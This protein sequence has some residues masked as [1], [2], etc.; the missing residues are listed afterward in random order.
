MMRPRIN[1]VWIKRDIRSQDHLPLYSAEQSELPYLVIY[2]FEPSIITYKDTS[3]RH[4]QFQYHAIQHLNEKWKSCNK[5][6]RV[7][8]AE[9]IEVFKLI[10]QHFTIQHLFSYRE[11][12][13]AIT[14]ERDKHVASFCKANGIEW[15]QSQRD[16]ILRGNRNREGWDKQWFVT[17]HSKVIE[18]HHTIREQIQI[19]EVYN[20][21]ESFLL[22]VNNFPQE[23][24]PPG[25][26]YAFKYLKSFVDE[27]GKNY[28]RHISKPLESRTGCMRISP[29]ISWGNISVR[30]AYQFVYQSLATSGFKKP[31]QNA[32]TRL[33]W[34]CH[35]IQKFENE[36]AY[37]TQC[38][39]SGYELLEHGSN[40][41]FIEAWKHGQTGY[42]LVDACMRCLIKTGWINFRMRAMLVSFLCFHLDQ[43]WRAGVYH[44]AQLFLD[45]EPGIHYPQFQMQAGTTGIN[46]VRIYNPIKQSRD[47]DPEGVF[48]RLWV[49]ELR[50]VP[51]DFIHEPH[52][53]SQLEQEMYGVSIGRD[54]PAPIVDLESSGKTA[55]DKIWG[56]RK[57]EAVK[58]DG[59]RILDRHVRKART[60]KEI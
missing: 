56:H 50:F 37:E 10:N 2:I 1:V 39:N 22:Q 20:L 25:E 24:Q 42:P 35:F 43:D 13:T 49:P 31:L 3:L 30:Q 29:Y 6:V 9:A 8:Y 47:H 11:S 51:G 27:R 54:Y 58:L 40:E 36:C 34:H 26:D 38:V 16:G 44:L 57:H 7:F 18:N 5:T 55:R 12:G 45:Y 28:S 4:L 15:T 41:Q 59:K 46:T 60:K 53:M 33:H 23:F 21:P 32:L 52:K 14:F 19:P 17:M 48:I